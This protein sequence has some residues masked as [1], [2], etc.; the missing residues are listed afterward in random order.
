MRSDRNPNPSSPKPPK[1]AALRFYFAF[2]GWVLASLLLLLIGMRV[3]NTRS[4]QFEFLILVIAGMLLRKWAGAYLGVHGNASQ[5]GSPVLVQTGPYRFSRNPLYLS[6]LLVG[7]GL[8]LFANCLHPWLAALVLTALFAHHA[9]LVKWEER[10]LRIQWGEAYASYLRTTPR[11][12]GKSKFFATQGG[13]PQAHWNKLWA[14]QGRNLLYTVA[15]V[16]LI[17]GASRWK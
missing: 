5:A 14:W 8:V 15:A 7:A 6:N 11:W 12:L 3:H 13:K 1:A 16:A 10:S 9:V 2:R 4:L 17:W